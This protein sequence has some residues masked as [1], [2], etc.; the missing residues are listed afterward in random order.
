MKDGHEFNSHTWIDPIL[1]KI[2]ARAIVDSLS[3]FDPKNRNYYN[4]IYNQFI[5]N[6]DKLNV[7][8]VSNL[9]NC[10]VNDFVS[11]HNSF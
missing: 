9:S 3:Q 5:Q 6:L 4:H 8:I 11:F 1:V 2:Q 10:K 7:D